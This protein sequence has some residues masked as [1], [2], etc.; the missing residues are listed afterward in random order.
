MNQLSTANE[1]HSNQQ[2]HFLQEAMRTFRREMLQEIDN[3]LQMMRNTAQPLPLPHP[4]MFMNRS[5][6]GYPGM[7]APV[8]QY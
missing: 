3:R 4:H 8:P 5:Q 2:N 6:L 7:M 1:S